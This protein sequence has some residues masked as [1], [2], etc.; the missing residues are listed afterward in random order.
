MIFSCEIL[1]TDERR[2]A[3]RPRIVVVQTLGKSVGTS[4]AR[5]GRNGFLAAR[6]GVTP[7]TNPPTLT[8]A[9]SSVALSTAR[10]K[11]TKLTSDRNL[12]LR[13]HV[14]IPAVL[15][16]RQHFAVRPSAVTTSRIGRASPSVPPRRM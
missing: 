12:E 11:A 4:N 9:A 5:V 15:G 7:P 13:G 8:L 3:A 10:S 14:E 6:P 16:D 1:G 2:L